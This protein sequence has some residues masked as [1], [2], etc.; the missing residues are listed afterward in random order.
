MKQLIAI[1]AVISII[2]LICI[3]D[4]VK[5]TGSSLTIVC[6]TNILADSIQHICGSNARVISLMGPGIDPHVYR[7]RESDVR[8]LAHADV[9]IFNGLHLEGKII[10]I[11]QKMNRY[12]PVINASIRLPAQLLL[13]T[14]IEHMHD[15]HIW[16]DVSLWMNVVQAISEQLQQIDSKH[17]LEY[18]TKTDIYINQ[19][20]QLHEYVLNQIQRIPSEQRILVTAHDAFKYFGKQYGIEVVGLQG[21]S[22]DA[23]I[24]IKEVTDLAHMISEKKIKALFTESCIPVRTIQA[25]QQAVQAQGWSVA[26]GSELY[27]DA[28][29]NPDEL[30]GT[31]IGMIRH[32]VDTIVEALL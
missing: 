14:E 20:Q 25:V 12:V 13:E 31:Y 2:A 19:L 16:H 21:T 6:T 7:A 4:P 10:D 24:S 22:T 8:T 3:Q 18:K 27:A 15:P 5:Q 23:Q 1:A 32:N 17:A 26:I 29:G 30:G 11:L 9:I 28:L